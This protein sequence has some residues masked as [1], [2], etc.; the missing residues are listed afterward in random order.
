[1]LKERLRRGLTNV[2]RN[3][4]GLLVKETKE[5]I[6]PLACSQI[7]TSHD[8]IDTFDEEMVLK[9]IRELMKKN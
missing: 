7:W 4:E 2:Y 5:G 6:M 3:N 9:E 8:E 1:M